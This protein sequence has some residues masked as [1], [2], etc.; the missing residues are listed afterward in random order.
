MQ[1]IDVKTAVSKI[2][3]GS[4]IAVSSFVGCSVPEYILENIEQEFLN[5]G[6]PK[7]LTVIWDATTGNGAGLGVDHLGHKGLTERVICSHI[8]F[9]KR[10]Q[11]MV[12]NNEIEAHILP[13]GAM[14]QLYRE[15][16]AGRPGFFSK[17]GLHTYVDP[18]L[19]GARGNE[20]TKESFTEVMKIHDEEY[21]FY[22]PIPM[23][24]AILRGTT[25]DEKGN[26][27]CERETYIGDLLV[28]ARAVKRKGGIVIAEVERIAENGALNPRDVIVPG[29]M[30]D[31][32]VVAPPDKRTQVLQIPSYNGA[33]AHEYRVPINDG[34]SA[35]KLN[36]RKIIARRAA[37]EL[38]AGD[39]INL[40]IGVPTGVSAVATEEGFSDKI[41]MT[42][43]CGQV[44]GVPV[45]DLA[46]GACVNPDYVVDSCRQFEWYD[47]GGL[48]TAFL[49]A[50][51]VDEQG[52]ANVSKFAYT[53]GPGGFIN[54]AHTARKV[55][56]CGTL[57]AGGLKVAVK[58][59]KLEILQEGRTKKYIPKVKQVTFS[60]K[61]AT[62][63]KQ[64]IMYITE[65]AVFRLI[66]GE[67]V[68][69]EIAPGIDLQHQ[70]LSQIDFP[71]RVAESL[72][73]MDERI[74][75][76]EKMGLKI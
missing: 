62:E 41:S 47:G 63:E 75:K 59:G 43:E 76:D 34:A 53:V 8:S 45:G 16:G 52:N 30:I 19:E 22:K 54:I 11:G 20:K 70:V 61:L 17:I 66:N 18:R 48:N 57:T 28:T 50:A 12:D 58:F 26:M 49:G 38:H 55:C 6:S 1:V 44:G 72:K 46:F 23:D 33:W 31:Y 14:S 27:T 21:L 15:M 42:V 68:L 5:N 40:G 64:D 24:V 74:F 2:A 37:M 7:G 29:F 71:V 10:L 13:Y 56:F 60:G 4:A 73:I 67:V 32:V 3:D 69:T 9:H 35:I 39:I 25:V 36:E 51:E 65:R